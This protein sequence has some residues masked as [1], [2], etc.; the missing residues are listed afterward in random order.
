MVS[1]RSKFVVWVVLTMFIVSLGPAIARADTSPGTSLEQAIKIVKT[2]FEVPAEYKDFSSG[3]TNYDNRQVWNLNWNAV[4][5]PGG[6]GGS[7][8][9]KVDAECGE[10]IGMSIWQPDSPVKNREAK[11]S[12]SE[13]REMAVTFLNRVA[14]QR[15]AFLKEMPDNEIMNLS[16]YGPSTYRMRWQRV[17]NQIPVEGD[18]A[19]VEINLTNGEVSSYNLRW[20]KF[21]MP[22]STGIVT[23]EAA[24]QAFKD[25]EMLELQYL[26]DSK[27]RPLAS[28]L[29]ENQVSLVYRLVHKSSGIID[30]VNG[31]PWESDQQYWLMNEKRLSESAGGGADAAQSAIPLTPEEESEIGKTANLL[32]QEQAVAAVQKWIKAPDGAALRSANLEKDWQNPNLRIWNLQWSSQ[33]NETYSYLWARV[34]AATGEVLSFSLDYPRTGKETF[35]LDSK[36]ARD[37]AE[38]FLKQIQ[39]ERFAQVIFESEQESRQGPVEPYDGP[40][41][42]LQWTRLVNGVKCPN[43]GFNVSVDRHT[44]KIISFSLNWSEKNF[45]KPDG[46]LSMDKAE[47]AFFNNTPLTLVY[48]PVYGQDRAE[49]F[50]LFY[51]PLDP[52]QRIT[53]QIMDAFN[54]EPLDSQGKPLSKQ[55]QPYFFNDIAGHFAEKE[56]SLVGKA[57]FMGEYGSSFRPQE[58]V[59]AASLFRV[60][61]GARNG[62]YSV[63]NYTDD[64]V[65]MQA[66]NMGWLKET[67]TKDALVSRKLLAKVV[68]RSLGL[69]YLAQVPGI[70]RY[71]YQDKVSPA[72]EGYATLCWGLGII[73]GDGQNFN[74]DKPISRAEA[75]VVAVRLLGQSNR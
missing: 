74:P 3:F 61:I 48:S 75:A 70:Y 17:E 7:F 28:D 5:E 68:I 58:N 18:G 46:I 52:N 72:L 4:Q 53:S 71:P 73:K 20:S 45:P 8:N 44:Q 32:T 31:K 55:P 66:V 34:N 35:T 39:P 12:P 62:L 59:G 2:N 9:A 63:Q 56:I 54:G 29:D 50:K 26:L 67:I 10:I 21:E 24:E 19:D 51:A 22:D 11:F 16:S 27:I 49:C 25:A 38:A 33:K 60:L 15:V 43:N 36:G 23:R 14:S 6:K 13:A 42:S 57:G 30:A 64:E 47:Q 1:K 69:E 37:I 65:L 40:I 41:W